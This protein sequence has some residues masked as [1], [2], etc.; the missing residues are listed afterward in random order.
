MQ[1]DVPTSRNVVGASACKDDAVVEVGKKFPGGR[2]HIAGRSGA[3]VK[4]KTRAEITR[5]ETQR[6]FD[7][8]ENL[9]RS[10]LHP[11]SYKY[12]ESTKRV[13]QN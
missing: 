7:L 13:G 11:T 3:A 2:S 5:I 8:P 6:I 12:I 10:Q 1:N 4:R 9:G